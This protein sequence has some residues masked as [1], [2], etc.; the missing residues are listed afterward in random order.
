MA[1][2]K[3]S[4]QGKGEASKKAAPASKKTEGKKAGTRYGTITNVRSDAKKGGGAGSRNKLRDG[5]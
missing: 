3:S 5:K 4:K 2:G 1:A